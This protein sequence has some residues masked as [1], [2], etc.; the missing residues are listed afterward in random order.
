M[1]RAKSHT[2][3][4]LVDSALETFWEHGYQVVSMGD[5][6]RETGVSRGGIYTDFAGKE[7]LFLA[8]LDRYQE[9]V[10]TPAFSPVEAEGAGINA[11]REYL[12]NLLARYDASGGVGRGCLVGNTL[13]Q[14]KP[15]ETETRE[16]LDAHSRRLTAGFRQALRNENAELGRL[17][18]GEIDA[19]ARFA[20]V[21]VQGLW[22][23]SRSTDDSGA[24]HQL[25]NTLLACLEARVRGRP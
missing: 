7:Q 19:L 2:R 3:T 12:E 14:I 18:D 11:I 4:S 16:R 13:G 5:L 23:F 8:C 24:M 22:S 6:V 15:E 25:T 9:V 17:S 20:M 10:V 21:S 1:P